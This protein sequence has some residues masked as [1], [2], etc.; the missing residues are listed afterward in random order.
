MGKQEGRVIR[1][2]SGEVA[3]SLQAQKG[4][5]CMSHHFY[6]NEETIENNEKCNISA[7]HCW[8]SNE[9]ARSATM[10]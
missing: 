6:C 1:P 4:Y 10:S 9:A 2:L 3:P 5:T 7:R 8:V